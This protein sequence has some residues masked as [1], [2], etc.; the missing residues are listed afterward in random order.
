MIGKRK[1]W[2]T[3]EVLK[4]RFERASHRRN[5]DGWMGWRRFKEQKE[6]A[7]HCNNGFPEAAWIAGWRGSEEGG[8]RWKNR[9]LFGAIC[10]WFST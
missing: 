10:Y 3:G 8:T 1:R 2:R 6:G 4:Q 9:I 5:F 7:A